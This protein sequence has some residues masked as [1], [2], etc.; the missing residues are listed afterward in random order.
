MNNRRMLR[1]RTLCAFAGVALAAPS[2]A[3]GGPSLTRRRLDAAWNIKHLDLGG[4]D[5]RFQHPGR[6]MSRFVGLTMIGRNRFI[7]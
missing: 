5:L 6:N 2:R 4:F 3:P 1:R 7:R